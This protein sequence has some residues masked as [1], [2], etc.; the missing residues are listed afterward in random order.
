MRMDALGGLAHAA[1]EAP[2]SALWHALDIVA[3]AIGYDLLTV[4]RFHEEVWEVE[5]LHST[6]PEA[7]PPGGR[8]AKRETAWGTQVL[9]AGDP[10]R[11]S[12]EAAIRWAFGD[13]DT[14]L[15]LGLIHVLNVPVRLE[16]RTVGTVNLLRRAPDYTEEDVDDL[17]LIAA[18]IAGRL[19]PSIS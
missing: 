8:K 15:G 13:A 12:G 10:Y 17:L 16:A 7:Y 6:N 3:G 5:R 1:A 18:L 19:A 4:M 14:I 9:G 11:G 2:D